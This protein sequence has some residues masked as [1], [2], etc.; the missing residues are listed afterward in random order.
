[1]QATLAQGDRCISHASQTQKIAGFCKQL[2][3]RTATPSAVQCARTPS[4]GYDHLAIR[5]NEITEDKGKTSARIRWS[6]GDGTLVIFARPRSC[7]ARHEQQHWASSLSSSLRTP[8]RDFRGTST[9]LSRCLP[10]CLVS[11]RSI[12]MRCFMLRLKSGSH[13][14]RCLRFQFWLILAT[15]LLIPRTRA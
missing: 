1:M 12:M 7:R 9:H 15:V 11:V 13:H 10:A 6:H 2:I 14:L 4:L 3:V 5:M 8:F